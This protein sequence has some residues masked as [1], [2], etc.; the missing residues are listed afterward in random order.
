M[1]TVNSDAV[2]QF[3]RRRR[4]RDIEK[5]VLSACRDELIELNTPLSACNDIIKANISRHM[6]E[7]V[8]KRAEESYRTAIGDYRNGVHW[9][10]TRN[11]FITILKKDNELEK[12]DRAD[13]LMCCLNQ[14]LLDWHPNL[15]QIL[16]SEIQNTLELEALATAD[17][18]LSEPTTHTAL[19]YYLL[20]NLSSVDLA[21]GLDVKPPLTYIIDKIVDGIRQRL[22]TDDELLKL[23]SNALFGELRDTGWTTGTWPGSDN[24]T[25]STASDM[26][27]TKGIV[28]KSDVFF[29][30]N[31]FF[32]TENFG[33]A[34]LTTGT[35][36]YLRKSDEYFVT[37]SPACDL[38]AR[39]PGS[40]QSWARSIHPL[41]P[42]VVIRLQPI[43][44]VDSALCEA[45][46][47]QY[48]FLEHGG[49][50]KAFKIL[51]EVGQ[52][53]YEILFAVNEG[54]VRE[55]GGKT[56]FS[57]AR[58]FPAG[59]HI[60]DETSTFEAPDDD[61]ALVSQEFEVI[62]QLRN[63]HAARVLQ[64]MG[65]HLSRIGL[66]FVNMPDK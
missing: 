37:A 11:T 31:G 41:T 45:T 22:S 50:K 25:M 57:V 1:P 54:R 16:V 2:K 36:C 4:I 61:H 29:R 24:V 27:R 46:R 10:Q 47:S 3:A 13:R 8:G 18:I 34:H 39:K 44:V 66:D 17:K 65:Q 15:F 56:V 23:A 60:T 52:P 40:G 7:R 9:I 35:I 53:S 64:I 51:N 6:I 14:A 12:D 58:L 26:A 33:H 62:S 20:E 5:D 30:L 55:V 38:E 59:A 19:W 28:K 42:M 63:I 43:D 48:I 49:K 32:S 21:S